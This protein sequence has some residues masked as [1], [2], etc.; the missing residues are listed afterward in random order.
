MNLSRDALKRV[1]EFLA[2]LQM[3]LHFHPARPLPG[4]YSRD[5]RQLQEES[6]TRL[7]FAG[8]VLVS[9]QRTV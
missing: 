7:V 4:I 5:A 1:A 3:C 9:R 2:K 6:C 8:C